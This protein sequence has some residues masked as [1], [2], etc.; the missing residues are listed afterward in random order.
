[1]SAD[2]RSNFMYSKNSGFEFWV[3]ISYSRVP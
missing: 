2:V 1:M 3:S